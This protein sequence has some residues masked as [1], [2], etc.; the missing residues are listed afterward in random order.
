[1]AARRPG[2]AVIGLVLGCL[3]LAGGAPG[4][5]RAGEEAAETRGGGTGSVA[6]E[7]AGRVAAELGAPRPRDVVLLVDASQDAAGASGSDVDGDGRVDPGKGMHLLR[8]GMPKIRFRSGPDSILAAEIFAARKIVEALPADTRIGVVVMAQPFDTRPCQMRPTG[9]GARVLQPLTFDRAFVARA[10]DR[11]AAT[12]PS[13]ASNLAE[14]LKLSVSMLAG[15]PGRA[16]RPRPGAE[17]VTVLL[18]HRAPTFPFG[19]PYLTGPDD[20]A[21]AERAAV[22]ASKVG[23]RLEV[24][25]FGKG[26]GFVVEQLDR[27]AGLTG[28]RLTRIEDVQSETYDLGGP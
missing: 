7:R 23:V 21:L 14:G 18:G 5:A 1:M 13:G 9:E 2:R 16:S 25:A 10:L 17:R 3:A 4:A 26:K 20:L 27:I 6:E 19:S 8:R 12:E 15:L 11:L 22:V 28:G 24:L